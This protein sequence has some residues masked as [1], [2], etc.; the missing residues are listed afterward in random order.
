MFRTRSLVVALLVAAAS[1]LAALGREGAR[2]A[3]LGRGPDRAGGRVERCVTCHVR[4]EEDPGG[5]HARAALGC[6]PCHLGNPYAFDEESAHRGMEPEPGALATVSLTCG[7]AGC[8][9][10]EAARVST[11]LMATARGIVSVDRFVFGERPTPDGLQTMAD[12]LSSRPPTPAE[13]HLG[14]LCAGCHLGARRG[15]RDDAI[16]GNG[17]GCSACHVERRTEGKLPRPHPAVDARIGD[18]RCLG[19]HSRSGRISLSYQGLAEV[20]ASQAGSC[21]EP[22]VLHDGRPAC[23]VEPDVHQAAGMACVDCHLHTDLMGDG[24]RHRHEEEQVEVTCEA[25]HGPVEPA[26]SPSRGGETTWASVADPVTRDVLRMRGQERLPAERVRLGRRGTPLWNLRPAPDGTAWTLHRKGSDVAL[27]TKQTPPDANHR[28]PGHERLTCSSCHTAWAPSCTTCHT[29]FDPA[30]SQWDFR[31]AAATKW[32]WVERSE[33]YAW[34]PPALGVT[35]DGRIVPAVPGMILDLDA[36]AAGGTKAS[37]RLFAPAEPH[38]TGRKARTC[39]SCHL[40]SVAPG[41]GTGRLDLTGS[42]P[43]FS[44]AAPAPDDPALA[45]DGWTAL[46]APAPGKGTRVGFRSLSRGEIRRVL[47]VGACLPCHGTAADPVWRDFGAA[48]KRLA[49]GR[50]PRCQGRAPS[51][52]IALGPSR[53][54]G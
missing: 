28:L 20:E 25:C 6:S 27:A 32:A 1:L 10:R 50:V 39:E 34:G 52:T 48:R 24:V 41:L 13:S 38:T 11:S 8:H 17:S 47:A 51:W 12:V 42:E 4:P 29:G 49:A 5:A 18:D 3:A 19:C 45:L 31:A 36:T 40:S 23:R 53:P 16:H 46:D 33:G 22:A 2:V 14:K 30:R 54:G 9:E 43:R 26:A 15:N 44:P 21:A 7:R 35:G 37:H